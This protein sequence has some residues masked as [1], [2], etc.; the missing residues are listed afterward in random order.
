[1]HRLELGF[2]FLLMGTES[3]SL[4]NWH[5]NEQ[6]RIHC[7]RITVQIPTFGKDRD[8]LIISFLG[9]VIGP[10]HLG[11]SIFREFVDNVGILT[12]DKNHSCSPSPQVLNQSVGIHFIQL[13]L[14]TGSKP[15]K[16]ADHPE[17]K[18][19]WSG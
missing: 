15:R 6:V 9:C 5:S 8:G 7:S 17:P 4:R 3:L 16:E 11:F 2:G 12:V 1:M 19:Q 18:P 14:G 13:G 10:D